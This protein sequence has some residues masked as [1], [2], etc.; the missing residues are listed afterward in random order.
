MNASKNSSP[1]LMNFVKKNKTQ[2][3]NS[4]Q[5][6]PDVLYETMREYLCLSPLARKGY[7]GRAG[8]YDMLMLLNSAQ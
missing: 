8:A 3:K 6:S 2:E 5:Y 1:S 7:L 4:T